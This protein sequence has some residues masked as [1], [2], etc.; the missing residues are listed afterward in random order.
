MLTP[1]WTEKLGKSEIRAY[2]ASARGGELVCRMR[3][4]RVALEG[5]CVFYLEGEVT[6]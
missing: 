1:Y 2:Q 3:G 5:A 6:F 4:N